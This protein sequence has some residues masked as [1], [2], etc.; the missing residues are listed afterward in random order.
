MLAAHMDEVGF[1]L[2]YD[3]GGGLYRFGVAGGVDPR[4]LA[5]KQVLVGPDQTPGVIGSAPIHLTAASERKNAVTLNSLR[6]DIGPGNG[7]KIQDRRHGRHLQPNLPGWGQ[8]Y[9][10]KPWMTGWV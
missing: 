8:V 6:I 1:M 4:N 2:T 7:G 9:G 3:E 5:G 10:A